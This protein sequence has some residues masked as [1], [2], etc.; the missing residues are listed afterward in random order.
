MS[1]IQ[2]FV[3]DRGRDRFDIEV[4]SDDKVIVE[5]LGIA[6]SEFSIKNN[7]E[8]SIGIAGV[9]ISIKCHV[10]SSLSGD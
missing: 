10:M 5:V 1:V 9:Y 3:K 8:I 6:G 4:R 7:N 2:G